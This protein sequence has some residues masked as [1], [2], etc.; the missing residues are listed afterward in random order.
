MWETNTKYEVEVETFIFCYEY[1]TCLEKIY[2]FFLCRRFLVYFYVV[3][4]QILNIINIDVGSRYTKVINAKKYSLQ[5]KYKS[6]EQN[7]K[8]FKHQKILRQF[9][10]I[11]RTPRL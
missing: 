10:I 7:S 1:G 8:L 4:Q 6:S 3:E 9:Q 5:S 11:S 2:Y